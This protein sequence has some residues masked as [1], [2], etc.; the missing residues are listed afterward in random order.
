MVRYSK[1]AGSDARLIKNLQLRG[2]YMYPSV[3]NILL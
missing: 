1:L 2:D 3:F